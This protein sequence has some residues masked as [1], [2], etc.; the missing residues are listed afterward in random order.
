MD[1]NPSLVSGLNL[2]ADT[3]SKPD[4]GGSIDGATRA[5][6]TRAAAII[7]VPRWRRKKNCRLPQG[8]EHG[9]VTPWPNIGHDTYVRLQSGPYRSGCR[10]RARRARSSSL[11]LPWSSL[12]LS[13]ARARA[14]QSWS[15][16]PPLPAQLNVR[17]AQR[18]SLPII[19]MRVAVV[20]RRARLWDVY[21]LPSRVAG[22]HTAER[23]GLA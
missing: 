9:A 5:K 12:G 3:R 2:D 16:P 6:M 11:S 10:V 13:I 19:S 20:R 18:A 15:T 17:V 22:Q 14:L 23:E 4:T 1:H 8:R 21:V 7:P